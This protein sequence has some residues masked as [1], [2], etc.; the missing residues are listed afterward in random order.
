MANIIEIKGLTKKFVGKSKKIAPKLALDGINL[1]VPKGG[2]FGIIGLNGAGKTTA[3]KC[4]LSL[5][6]E[7]EGEILIDGKSA[8]D[9]KARKEVAYMPERFSPNANISAYEYLETYA[10]LYET[11][12]EREKIHEL[13]KD[14]ELNLDFLKLKI[15]ECS[16]GTVQKI[17][18]L[19]CL[20]VKASVIILDEPTSGLDI[21]AR[22]NLKKALV[23]FS[24]TKT[25]IFSS[26]ILAD[27]E[28]LAQNIAVIM[29]GKLRFSGSPQLF[30]QKHGKQSVEKSFIE[31]FEGS[32]K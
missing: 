28:E 3:I 2:I 16:K 13:A 9:F 20:F 23:K 30:M 12:F 1:C 14:L 7:Y 15:R 31:E 4:I 6:P 5:I 11:E 10:K 26:H 18:L 19:G 29:E 8:I 24:Q 22:H 27:V 25:I 32:E 17:G 21:I